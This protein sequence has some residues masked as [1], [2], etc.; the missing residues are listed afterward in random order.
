MG[1]AF[2][3]VTWNCSHGVESATDPLCPKF[4]DEQME[5]LGQDM[6]IR[7]DNKLAKMTAFYKKGHQ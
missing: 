2:L 3:M 6:I 7:E 4:V 5:D 1:V